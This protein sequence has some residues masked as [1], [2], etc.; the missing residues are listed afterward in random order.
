LHPQNH[1]LTVRDLPLGEHN[2]YLKVNRRQ[3][4]C[5]GCGKKF[6]E[7]F[8]FFKK[9]SHFTERLKHKIIKEIIS[10]DI[11]NVAER[12]GLSE[13]E[14]TTILQEAGE[15]L[16]HKK[17]E[18]LKRLGIDEIAFTKGQKNYCAVLVDIEKNN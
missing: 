14:V 10:G 7:E 17:P 12:N 9:R 4:K 2:V 13:Q 8:N 15:N 6:S 18:N 16:I 3:L 1:W 5:Q 11:K